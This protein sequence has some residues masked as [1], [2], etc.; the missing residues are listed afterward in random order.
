MTNDESRRSGFSLRRWSARKHEVAREGGRTAMPRRDTVPGDV[1]R[2][3][4][5]DIEARA[6]EGTAKESAMHARAG[7]AVG[8]ADPAR[9]GSPASNDER[10]LE[11]REA[12]A[13]SAA[14]SSAVSLPSIDSLSIDSDYAPF[15]QSGVDESLK[16]GALKKLFRDPR[17]NVMDGLDV[18]IDDYSKPDPIDPEIVRTLVQARYIFNPPA[19]RVNEQGYVEDVQDDAAPLEPSAEDAASGADTA[20]G[21]T[22]Q[23]GGVEGEAPEIAPVVT[24][25]ADLDPVTRGDA[26]AGTPLPE[27]VEAREDVPDDADRRASSIDRDP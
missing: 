13:A 3:S 15:M 14:Q 1:S 21:E 19:T 26:D 11:K 17:F 10:Q 2:H 4:V 20:N 9:T 12:S 5:P 23:A 25:A 16:R 6:P 18:Y 7:S 22:A 24:D 8:L 27:T